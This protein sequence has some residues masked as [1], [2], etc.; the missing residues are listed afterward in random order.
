[1]KTSKHFKNTAKPNDQI[2][3]KINFKKMKKVFFIATI[4][5]AFALFTA[6]NSAISAKIA[7]F[8][9]KTIQKTEYHKGW[10]DGHCEG[11]KDVKGKQAYCPYPP[12][13]SYPTYPKST[14]SYRDGYNDGFKR[15]M[16][17]ARK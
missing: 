11:W 9:E 7:V 12:Y 6:F 15:G 17:D 5:S 14:D 8:A 3:R 16:S 4:I 2:S 13:P 10:D 1:V